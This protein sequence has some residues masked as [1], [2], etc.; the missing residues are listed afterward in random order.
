[1]N[2]P[3]K[4]IPNPTSA[5][6]IEKSRL[7]K[8]L[9]LSLPIIGVILAGNIMS[10]IDT[11]MVGRLGDAALASIGIASTLFTMFG[12]LFYGIDTGVQAM[13]ARRIGE[14]NPQLTGMTLNAGILISVIAGT[15]CVCLGYLILPRVCS[16]MIPD[17]EVIEKGV[18]YL[19]MRMPSLLFLGANIA[20]GAYW[21]GIG[22]PKWSLLV[23][24]IQLGSNVCF[25]YLLIF[26]ISG[27]PR[28]ETAGAGLGSTLAVFVA[29]LAHIVIGLKHARKNGFLQ[30]LPD[31]KTSKTII[32]LGLPVSIQQFSVMVGMA[33][34][35]KIVGLLGTKEVAASNAVVVVLVA[36]IMLAVGM[37]L[38]ATTFVGQALGRN[39]PDDA[40]QWGW[41]TAKV[42]VGTIFF[43]SLGAF[44]F[45]ETVLGWFIINAATL[46]IATVPLQIAM[47]TGLVDTFRWVLNFALRGAGATKVATIIPFLRQW[48][49]S[50]PLSWFAGIHLGYGLI[51]IFWIF[52][53]TTVLETVIFSHIWHKGRWS[54]IQV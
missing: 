29:L 10:L 51:G 35:L 18:S 19:M 40:K 1:M 3:Y 53:L 39:D 30:S 22:M 25:N 32:K 46:R 14:D 13:V 36:Q 17:S 50:L 27:F 16:V 6:F 8:I 47:I 41:D 42:G 34:S 43:Y 7:K 5:I 26:G 15:V 11:A 54:R 31:S 33:I 38:A 28:L 49:L 24:L 23:T 2:I 4:Q 20:F 12:A 52:F 21:N 48:C 37:G 45:P 9:E 44:L